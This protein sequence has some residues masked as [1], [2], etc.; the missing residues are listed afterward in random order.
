MLFFV[1]LRFFRP[2]GG[3][4]FSTFA[5]L[6]TISGIALGVGVLIVV[7]SV[8]NGFEHQI[9]TRVLG[10][11]PHI[12]VRFPPLP[13]SDWT[14]IEK[15][16]EAHPNVTGVSPFIRL[17]A[18]LQREDKVHG[19]QIQGIEPAKEATLSTLSQYIVQGEYR[20][21]ETDTKGVLIGQQLADHLKLRLGDKVM[22][23][24]TKS[25]DQNEVLSS[26]FRT[27]VFSVVAIYNSGTMVDTSAVFL[28]LKNAAELSGMPKDAATG[29]HV[30]LKDIFASREVLKDLYL[31]FDSEIIF[32]DWMSDF[33]HLFNHIATSKRM[34]FL[35]IIAVLLV[36]C[37]NV[38]SVLLLTVNRRIEDIAILRTMGASRLTVVCL[39][40]ILGGL[41][42]MMGIFFGVAGGV[43]LSLN[44][45]GVYSGVEQLFGLQ[46]LNLDVYP[47]SFLSTVISP[48][49]ILVISASALLISIV[50]SIYPAWRAS[51]ID[52][53]EVLKAA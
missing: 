12:T 41:F 13:L 25:H 52:P 23:A 27:A 15:K 50:L 16:I 47:V 19:V 32:T 2:K 26:S 34:I 43:V 4:S 11:V 40:M 38:L 44:L 22:I 36:A 51:L 8:V 28:N 3:K 20:T 30:K 46:I 1:A 29:L 9:Q 45:Q 37:F 5:T 7:M 24:V 35:S 53:A 48:N 6:I 33:N 42:A 31:L 14:P 39:F 18:I 49:D 21:L 10:M 17:N